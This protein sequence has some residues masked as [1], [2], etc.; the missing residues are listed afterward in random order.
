MSFAPSEFE[1]QMACHFYEVLAHNLTVAIR[2]IWSDET[3]TRDS[4]P[5]GRNRGNQHFL[6]NYLAWR[7]MTVGD[8]QAK[9][10]HL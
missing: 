5:P 6:S 2:S 7:A 1:R 4:K 8:L 3:I 9:N 10:I